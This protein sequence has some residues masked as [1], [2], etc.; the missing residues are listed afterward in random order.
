MRFK[1][2]ARSLAPIAALALGAMA[3]GCDGA[4]ININGEEGKKLSELDLTGTPPSEL[5]VLGPD[6]VVLTPG[7]KLA[8][9]VEGDPKITDQLR[10]T[11]KDGT[12]GILRENLRLGRQ[13][14]IAT[15]KVTMPA[16]RE[17]TVAGSGELKAPA[18]ASDAKVTIAGSGLMEAGPLANEKLELTIA[19]S[20]NYKASGTLKSLDMTIAGSGNAEMAG[21]KVDDA[22]LSIAGSGRSELAS[23]GEVKADIMGSGEVR[24]HGRA[25]CT[26][27][28]MG[29]GRLVC[30]P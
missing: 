11:L 10:F 8:I 18:L 28:S 15:V 9:A 6:S 3:A 16:P 19:G 4:K 25:R 13:D 5:V 23:D 27:K 1:S 20:G 12:L 24:V 7:N 22:K 26:V 30:E 17:V 21:L 2:L 14:G 29:S